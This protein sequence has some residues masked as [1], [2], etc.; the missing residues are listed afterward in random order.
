MGIDKSDVRTVIHFDLPES[1]ESFYQESGRAGRDGNSSYSILLRSVG[2]EEKLMDRIQSSFPPIK[3]L[4]NVMQQFCN[5]H[6]I[7]LGFFEQ[8]SFEVDFDVMASKLK[9]PKKWFFM[10]LNY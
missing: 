8:T 7:P 10:P 5:M 3:I 1:M 6:Q 2:D 4:Q 9:L